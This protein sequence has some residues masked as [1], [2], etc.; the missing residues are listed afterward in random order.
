MKR[1]IQKKILD[2]LSLKIVSGEIKEGERI[3]ID[4][5]NNKVVFKTQRDL[6]KSTKKKKVAVSS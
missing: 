1:V 5:K 4:F 3:V 6:R 2:P